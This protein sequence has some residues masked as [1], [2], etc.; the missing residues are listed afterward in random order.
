MLISA[1][2]KGV[3]LTVVFG[4]NHDKLTADH[5]IVS[6]ASCTTNCLAPVAKVLHDAIGI[7]RGLMTTIHRYTNDQK[8]LDQIHTDLRRARAAAMNM[9]PTTHRRRPSPWAGAARTEGQARRFVDPRADP[10]RLG[11]RPDLHARSATP[12]RRKSTP[13]SRPRPKAELKGVLGYTDEPLVSIDFN[14]DP[15]SL[16]GRQ[17]RDGGDRRQAGARRCPGTTTNGASRTAWSTRPA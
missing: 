11:R 10:E 12:P 1:P 8:I 6:N 5:L 17:P 13:C 14:H 9:I 15:H 4:V 7:E 16:D 3:D 2:A